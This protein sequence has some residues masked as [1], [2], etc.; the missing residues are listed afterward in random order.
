MPRFMIGIDIGTTSTK[1]VVYTLQGGVVAQHGVDYPLLSPVRDAAEQEPAEIHEAVLESL[2]CSLSLSRAAPADIACVS[3]SAAMHSLI[4][5]DAAGAPLTRSITWADNR[6]A[7]WA[8]RIK[9]EWGGDALYR[10]TGTPVHPMSPLAKLV[11]LR[12]EAPG[13]FARAAHFVG[14]KEYVFFRLFGDWL[15]DQSTAS[16]TGLLDLARLDW[17]AQALALAGIG[18]HQLSALV[19]TT[20]ARRGLPPGLARQLGLAADTPFVVGASDGVL[21]SL[22]LDA[23]RP[24]ELS[25][26]IGTSGA[27]RTVVD[28]PMTDPSGRSFCYALTPRHWVVGGPVNNG[29]I[30]LDWL[31]DGLAAAECQAA[32]RSG[33]DPHALLGRL[34][35]QAPP[36]AEGLLFHPYLSGERAPHWNAELRASFFGLDLRHRKEH[37]IRAA[38]EGVVFNLHGI[39]PI[40]E[41]LVGPTTCI[42][43]SGGFARSGLWR[44]MLA[45]IFDRE[46][47]VP[48]GFESSCLGAA[49]LGLYALGLVDSLQV[50]AGMVGPTQRHR[51]IARNVAV[52]ARLRA[53]FTALPGKLQEEYR[54]LAAFRRDIVQDP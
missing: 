48:E 44:Q 42:K 21:S 51:P 41:S 17:D 16:A 11:W 35:E 29:G 47:V 12:H 38:L 24:G 52:Y 2:R 32:E 54:L 34:A 26:G 45:D 1:A 30:V 27:L 5:V 23:L 9:A 46:L 28:R 10:R 13:V 8:A 14:I 6:A 49:V 37:M 3:F 18:R 53:V 33:D 36:G 4:A 50:V 40:L 31:R 15:V 20:H 22:G 7:P 25:L 43:A 19:P 39:L